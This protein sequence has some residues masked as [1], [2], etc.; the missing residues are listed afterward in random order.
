MKLKRSLFFFLLIFVYVMCSA[1]PTIVAS[2]STSSFPVICG[3]D[4]AILVASSGTGYTYHWSTGDT[5]AYIVTY[6]SGTYTVTVH[7]GADSAVSNPFSLTVDPPVVG[8]FQLFPDPN[9]PHLWVVVNQSTGNNLIY[10]WSWGDGSSSTGLSPSHTYSNAGDYTICVHLRDS[11]Y[12]A[13]DYCDTSTY[14][15]KGENQIV[16]VNVEQYPLSVSDIDQNS[17]SL[18]YYGQAIH[19]S[20][21]IITPSEVTL[22][23]MSDRV[24]LKQ[25]NW[26]GSSLDVN[27]IGSGVYV[28][29]I[30]NNKMSISRKLNIIR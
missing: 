15:F 3:G 10:G 27:A 11:S 2:I 19:F 14:L 24:V 4:S 7:A 28:V 29:T 25:S 18:K 22:Y 20:P 30:Q 17:I 1:R 23:D 8:Y 16:Q 13:R 6:I 5:S 26:L 9:T 12:C 21:T